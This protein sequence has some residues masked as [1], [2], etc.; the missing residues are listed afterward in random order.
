V[1]ETQGRASGVVGRPVGDM[2]LGAQAFGRGVALALRRPRLLALG[3][4]PA[5][6]AAVLLLGVLG[7]VLFFIR[8]E[9]EALTWFATDWTPWLRGTVR[10][11]AG[12]ALIGVVGMVSVLLFSA[13]AL[14]IGDPFYEKISESVDNAHGVP[15]RDGGQSWRQEWPRGVAESLRLLALAVPVGIVLFLAGFLPV[16]GQTVVPVLGALFGGWVLT[17]ELTG[18]PFARRGQHLAGR[19]KVLRGRRGAALG[20]GVCVFVAFLI[21]L[22]AVLFMT[23]AV[24]GATL[25]THQL[26]EEPES[27]DDVVG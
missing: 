7:L 6:L 11:L 19:R 20:F 9:S 15:H 8:S 26:T 17:L 22:G 13:L 12:A 16:L 24:I 27:P 25:L 5:V 18:T 21:P 1:R 10:V 2:L 3:L 23:P 4:I 14:T